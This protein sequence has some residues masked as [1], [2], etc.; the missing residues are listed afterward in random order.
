M[1]SPD[2]ITSAQR[3]WQLVCVIRFPFPIGM[4]H[5]ARSRL[6]QHRAVGDVA[7]TLFKK[8]EDK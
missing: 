4:N 3:D 6:P 2:T 1:S 7:A 5:I 8:G